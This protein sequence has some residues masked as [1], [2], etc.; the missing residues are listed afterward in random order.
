[1]RQ[2]GIS[3]AVEAPTKSH[4]ITGRSVIR[5]LSKNS[6]RTEFMPRLKGWMSPP[7][8]KK[9]VGGNL[10]KASGRNNQSEGTRHSGCESGGRVE[11]V[12]GHMNRDEA[13]NKISEQEFSL[14]LSGLRTQHSL[15]EDACSIPGLPLWVKDLALQR[16]VV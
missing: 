1:M 16:A 15:R 14:W 10:A 8:Q 12:S 6:N 2:P 5:K 4:G 7:P 3:T 11:G 13:M 9:S